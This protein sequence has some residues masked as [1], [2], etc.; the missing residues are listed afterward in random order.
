MSYKLYYY[1][2]RGLAEPIRWVLSYGGIE[3]EDIRAP[4]TGIPSPLPVEIKEKCTWGQVPLIEF[5]GKKLAQSLAITRYFARKFNLV[6]ADDFE[7]A[8]CD[9]YVDTCREFLTAWVPIVME[10]DP[11]KAKEKVVEVKKTVQEKYLVKLNKIVEKNGGQF[12]VGKK[13]TWADMYLAHVI[14]NVELLHDINFRD[15]YPA[16]KTHSQNVLNTPQIKKWIEKR[17]KTKF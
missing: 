10:K 4:I 3:F 17:P 6:G 16:L 13:L 2:G 1:D 12:L 14:N 11:E 7:A 9:E 5:D 8:Q 15:E